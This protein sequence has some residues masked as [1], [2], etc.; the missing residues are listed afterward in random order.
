M[1]GPP[2]DKLDQK[3]RDHAAVK[4]GQGQEVH[5]AE[6]DRNKGQKIRHRTDAR[7]KTLPKS[8][9][10]HIP[11]HVGNPHRPGDGLGEIDAFKEEPQTPQGDHKGFPGLPRAFGKGGGRGQYRGPVSEGSPDDTGIHFP[12]FAVFGNEPRL[13]FPPLT[14]II[15]GKG[16]GPRFQNPRKIKAVGNGF[17]VHAEDAVAG[18]KAGAGGGALRGHGL[19]QGIGPEIHADSARP[20][21]FVQSGGQSH[22]P[23]FPVPFNGNGEGHFGINGDFFLHLMGVRG[24]CAVY[25]DYPVPGRKARVIGGVALCGVYFGGQHDA[26]AQGTHLKARSP[27]NRKDHKG[28]ATQTTIRRSGLAPK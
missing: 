25:F 19:D 12:G 3:E 28:P 9:G 17:A 11:H 23:G 20:G 16:S 4:D 7:A 15:N 10:R 8:L 24:P 18:Q 22:A 27:N 26:A 1:D 5:H 2:P 13:S 14:R 6:G 21:T